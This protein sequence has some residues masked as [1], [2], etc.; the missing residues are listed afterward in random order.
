MGEDVVPPPGED[1]DIT[2]LKFLGVCVLGGLFVL[3]FVGKV[4]GGWW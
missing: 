4:N 1:P 2:V 3:C